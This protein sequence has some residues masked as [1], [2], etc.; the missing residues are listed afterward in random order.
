MQPWIVDTSYL[1]GR[2]LETAQRQNR[3]HA[4]AAVVTKREAKIRDLLAQIEGQKTRAD[5][6]CSFCTGL[7]MGGQ[8]LKHDCDSVY[9]LSID[10]KQ[11]E[12]RCPQCDRLMAAWE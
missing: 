12:V 8:N 3:E 9:G 1:H 7:P 10:R 2:E 11:D 5:C 6:E 4:R